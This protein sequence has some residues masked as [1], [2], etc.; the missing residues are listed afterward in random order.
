MS[1]ILRAFIRRNRGLGL[2]F[3][4]P[5]EYKISG[6][7]MEKDEFRGHINQVALT[8]EK[9][10][11]AAASNAL[12]AA[13]PEAVVYGE[14]RLEEGVLDIL[15]HSL[16]GHL[17]MTSLHAVSAGAAVER[18]LAMACAGNPQLRAY[19]ASTLATSFRGC[20][21]QNLVT[22]NGRKTL[23]LTWLEPS[24]TV[25]AAIFRDACHTLDEQAELQQ[26]KRNAKAN[27]LK[28]MT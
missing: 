22:E 28:S 26:N 5:P 19:C 4:A 18:F 27:I 16:S 2:M 12:R 17:I 9:S 21:H 11:T 3:E 24:D 7:V 8:T 14:L 10:F 6:P 20:L 13:S 25:R 15:N 23:Q 1:S